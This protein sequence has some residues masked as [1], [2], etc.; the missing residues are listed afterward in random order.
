M[1]VG[2]RDYSKYVATET[3]HSKTEVYDHSTSTWEPK[4]DYPFHDGIRGFEIVPYSSNFLVFGGAHPDGQSSTGFGATNVIAL[5]NPN[6]NNWTKVGSLRYS[7]HGFGLIKIENKFLI[8]GGS[9][10]KRTEICQITDEVI[11]CESREPSI[12]Y[13]QYYPAMTVVSEESINHCKKLT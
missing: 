7:R 6:S 11:D 10:H 9:R 4:N 5:F 1:A 2:S 3:G 13:F 12:N 8:M